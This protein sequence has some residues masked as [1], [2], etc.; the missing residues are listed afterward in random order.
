MLLPKSKLVF[1]LRKKFY[2]YKNNNMAMFEFNIYNV[3]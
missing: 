3:P 2:N 1:E